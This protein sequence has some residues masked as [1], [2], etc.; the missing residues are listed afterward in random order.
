MR[1]RVNSFSNGQTEGLQLPWEKCWLIRHKNKSEVNFNKVS[2][3]GYL[4]HEEI[5]LRIKYKRSSF[6]YLE[7]D[8]GIGMQIAGR[9][10]FYAGHGLSITYAVSGQALI[11]L[12]WVQDTFSNNYQE[13]SEGSEK[14]LISPGNYITQ[15]AHK[16]SS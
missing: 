8:F 7:H 11:F 12:V 16:R 14:L 3:R 13:T 2:E 1:V 6:W 4:K 9:L 10:L 5:N 15:S